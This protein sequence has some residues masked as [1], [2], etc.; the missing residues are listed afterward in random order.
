M[1]SIS[2]AARLTPALGLLACA[3]C[4]SLD[5]A[6]EPPEPQ[7][8]YTVTAE[9][10]LARHQP[11]IA[12]LQYTAAAASGTDDTLLERAVRVTSDALQPSLTARV[13]AR[14]I[15]VDPKSVEAHRAAAQAALALYKID[16]AAAHY[17][18]VLQTSPLGT[19]AEF[20]ALETYLGS[21]DNVFGDRQLADRLASSF[22][23]SAAALRLQGIAALR[24]DDPA[25][26]VRSLT[27]ALALTPASGGPAGAK[28]DAAGGGAAA[29]SG[30]AAGG[31]AKG[32]DKNIETPRAELRHT[33]ARARVLAGDAEQPLA[34]A[35]SQVRRENSPI[36]R[37]DYALLLMTAQRDSAAIE[38]LEILAKN[39]EYTAV[40]ERLI[41]LLEYQEGHL[42]AATERFAQLVKSEKYLDDAFFY[43]GLIADR[44]EDPEHAL[45]LYAQ[46]TSGD[47]ALPALLRATTILQK[48]GAPAAAEDLLDRLL[49][50]EP[51]RA[52]D[53]LAARARIY[54]DA[55]DPAHALEVLRRGNADYP[56][57]VDLQYAQASLFE[58]LGRVSDSLRELTTVMRARPEDPAAENALG[59]TLADHS[60]DLRRARRLIEHAYAASPKNSAILDSL[61][62]VLY[63]QGH[64]AEAE[65]YLRTAYRDDRG[66]DI[67]AHLGEVL[68]RLGRP[69]E[70]EHV[71]IEA[72]GTE[73]DNK[74]L[75][76]TRQR[77]HVSPPPPGNTAPTP[78][79]D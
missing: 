65:G 31:E 15:A 22:A 23:S 67:A 20:A 53:I 25:A 56:D 11:R 17:R 32:G 38:Q 55:G 58:E 49:E 39:S 46:V 21:N 28:S 72:T 64:L 5:R 24:A 42:E 12:A 33:L 45:R 60:R 34:D 40:A 51:E 16:D 27:A 18:I 44:S 4:A 9:M 61:G 29:N 2:T 76:A 7:S 47:N 19:E 77:F 69:A 62:W 52:P 59:Y 8:F 48:H 74:L 57:N 10:A 54:M 37:L 75:K 78:T 30:S 50:A 13:A 79:A 41:G 68:W 70:A 6:K 36:N 63:R 26:A 73:P 1:F 35:E 71:W 66:G 43:L 3:A 14:W